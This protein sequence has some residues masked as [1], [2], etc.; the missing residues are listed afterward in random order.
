MVQHICKSHPGSLG[1][2]WKFYPMW[3]RGLSE[4]PWRGQTCTLTPKPTLSMK[5]PSS[6]GRVLRTSG[7]SDCHAIQSYHFETPWLSGMMSGRK[8]IGMYSLA[9]PRMQPSLSQIYT[10]STRMSHVHRVYI[11]IDITLTYIAWIQRTY[12]H[13]H[14][15]HRHPRVQM[16]HTYTHISLSYTH[17]SSR[18]NQ[19]H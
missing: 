11:Y 14:H 16:Y 6:R 17:T 18:V 5:H 15:T 4:C 12:V 8:N 13:T 10:H 2:I 19:F 1:V 3:V 7:R 9:W